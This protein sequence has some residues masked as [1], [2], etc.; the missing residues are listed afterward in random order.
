MTDNRKKQKMKKLPVF[1]MLAAVLFYSGCGIVGL[2]GTQSQ[3]EKKIPAE[4]DL[5]TQKDKQILVLVEQPSWLSIEVNLRYYLT[6][7]IRE[8]LA[9]KVKVPPEYIISY[10][11]LSEFRSNRSDFSLL[12]PV[13]VGEAL[14]ADIVLLVIIEDYQLNEM[15]ETGYYGGFLGAQAILFETASGAKLWPEY[16]EGKS[17]RV[18]FEAEK[19]Q[20]AAVDRLVSACAYCITRYFYNCPK[21]K[22]KIFDEGNQ[23]G[24]E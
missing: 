15:A 22:F 1:F 11:E 3:Y 19:E 5:A 2:L 16:T 17:I 4:Y 24:W 18:G 23:A 9:L 8:N 10:N 21:Y 13:E 20:E 7:A 14:G 12:S 6:E